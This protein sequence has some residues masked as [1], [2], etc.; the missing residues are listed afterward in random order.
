[1]LIAELSQIE[2]SIGDIVKIRTTNNGTWLL[3][4]KYSNVKSVDWTQTYRTVGNQNGTIQLSSSLYEFDNTIVGYD[5]SLYDGSVF[6]S[7]AASELRIILNTLKNNIFIDN[8]RSQYLNL[9]FT[10]VRYA[11]SEQHYL[12]WIFKTSFVKSKHNVGEL[13]QPVNYRND[14]LSNFEDYVDEV[15]PYRTKVREYISSYSKTDIG[16][17][18]VTDFDIPPTYEGETLSVITTNIVNGNIESDNPAINSYPWKHWLDNV[19]FVI[20][21]I[22]LI[23]WI[24]KI[25]IKL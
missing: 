13:H 24:Q 4:E 18:S 20:I 1:M 19:G 23:K 10:C 5:G 12:D 16:E 3:L 25:T 14:N 11:L 9:F 8:M 17:L 7:V 2:S 6:D 22:K 15:K 21:S